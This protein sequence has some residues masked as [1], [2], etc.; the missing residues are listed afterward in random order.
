M[1]KSKRTD[2]AT[3]WWLYF[4]Q[5]A[6]GRIYTGISPDPVRRFKEHEKKQS[7]HMRINNPVRLMGALPVGNYREAI[8]MER[9]VKRMTH[10]IKSAIASER[11]WKPS[12]GNR[13]T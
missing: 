5:C 4:I 3:L 6:N 8:L 10:D 9:R 12:V 11:P 13:L 2:G 1:A 7:A